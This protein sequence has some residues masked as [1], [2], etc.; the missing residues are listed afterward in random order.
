MII[1]MMMMILLERIAS[2]TITATTAKVT[3]D[4]KKIPL[5]VTI[6]MMPAI[7]AAEN[8]R[9]LSTKGEADT[10]RMP[11]PHPAGTGRR[12]RIHPTP[13]TDM[14]QSDGRRANTTIMM[15]QRRDDDEDNP[16]IVIDEED[17]RPKHKQP[18]QYH[19][20]DVDRPRDHT[21]GTVLTRR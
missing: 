15:Q 10:R 11:E 7:A 8:K 20:V 16:A 17:C 12:G 21:V 18:H 14:I 1:M 19:P 5:T 9:R 2:I 6:V 3:N 13:A 4:H